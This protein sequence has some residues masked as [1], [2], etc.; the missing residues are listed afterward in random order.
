MIT[1]MELLPEDK[2]ARIRS[3]I[4]D[5][6]SAAEALMSSDFVAAKESTS[7]AEILNEIR[8]S[9]HDS[10]GISYVYLVDNQGT[11]S[12]VVDLREIV[13]AAEATLLG[14]LMIAPVVSATADSTREDLVDLF[15]RYQFHMIPV[16]DEHDHLLGVVH[17]RD[18][19]KGLVARARS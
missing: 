10:H 3:I 17:Y 2:A 18:V 8:H 14:D 12:G 7:I 19:M 16:V 9:G 1:M 13:L 4:S 6:E 15:A 5:L 11:L